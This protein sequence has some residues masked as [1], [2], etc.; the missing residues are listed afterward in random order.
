[1][2]AAAISRPGDRRHRRGMS[3]SPCLSTCR[4]RRPRR[5]SGRRLRKRRC[6]SGA[7]AGRERH[8]TCCTVKVEGTGAYH[9]GKTAKDC[10][11]LPTEMATPLTT[12]PVDRETLPI[13]APT[14]YGAHAE[15]PWTAEH[16]RRTKQTASHPYMPSS[17]GT[18]LMAVVF[19]DLP[20]A[21]VARLESASI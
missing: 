3:C 18:R 4:V 2:L 12:L 11:G 17:R 14:G 5:G 16:A 7:W 6:C 20:E 21:P 13:L 10:E 1:M 8:F 9:N 15:E 19:V